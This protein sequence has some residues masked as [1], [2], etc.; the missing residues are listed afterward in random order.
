MILQLEVHMRECMVLIV[1]CPN[2]CISQDTGDLCRTERRYLQEH[3]T[4]LCLLRQVNCNYCSVEITAIDMN[5]H[6]S[7]CV[8]L[9]I[10]CPNGCDTELIKRRD[11]T[12]HMSTECGLQLVACVY[13]LYGCE[14]VLERREREQH[15]RELC[16]VHC[17]LTH[18]FY[19]GRVEEMKRV[20]DRQ[21]EKIHCLERDNQ[22]LKQ[23]VTSALSFIKTP[24]HGKLVWRLNGVKKRIATREESY[25]DPIYVGL[26]KCQARINWC[27]EVAGVKCIGVYI[28]VMQGEWDGRLDW[29]LL[30]SATFSLKNNLFKNA[31]HTKRIEVSKEIMKTNGDFFLR[32]N[33]T[34]NNG[35]GTTKFISHTDMLHRQFY[36]LDTLTFRIFV[37]VIPAD[38][39]IT[40]LA[41]NEIPCLRDSIVELNTQVSALKLNN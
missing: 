13:S 26:Y 15:E 10:E 33:Y 17:R 8:E 12:R 20:Q 11:V 23:D 18:E 35:F 16:H 22:R 28:H 3:L 7:E 24:S 29:P 37:Q 31:N 25:S 36:H 14:A 40:Q 27:N 41:E 30:N 32:P 38:S 5:T 34:R 19:S 39:Q 2:E 6:L 1:P 21:A 9:C 4:E